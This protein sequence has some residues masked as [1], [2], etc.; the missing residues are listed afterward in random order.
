MITYPISSNL[1][2]KSSLQCYRLYNFPSFRSNHW[3]C[4]VRKSVLGN[5]AKFTGKHLRQSLFFNKVAGWGDCFWSFS[6]L[7]LK[8]SYLFHFSRKMNWKKWK[9]PVGVQIFTSLLEYRFDWR[10]RFQKKLTDGYLI[11]KYV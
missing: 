8:I 11:K 6:C 7:L 9:Y 3:R 2:K 4:S 1:C 5:F 10:Q